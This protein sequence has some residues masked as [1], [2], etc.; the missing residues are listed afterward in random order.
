[1]YNGKTVAAVVPAYNE[2][3]LIAD[4]IKSIPEYFDKVYVVNDGSSDRTAE[5][6]SAF[7]NGR[8]KLINHPVNK[9]VGG[10]IISGYK[11]ALDDNMD[12]AVVMAGDN[13]MDPDNLSALLAPIFFDVAD[14]T[15]GDRLSKSGFQK[16]M[17]PWRRLGNFLLTWLTRIAAGNRSIQD[18]QNGYTAITNEALKKINLDDVYPWYGYCN[19]M[20]VK[21]SAYKMRIMDVPMPARYGKERSKIRYHKYIPKVSGL[22][23]RLFIWRLIG[24]RRR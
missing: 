20:L 5:I 7:T 24:S 1:M 18:P 13:Q 4:T 12:I 3:N 9:G 6:V 17:S 11:N 22:L 10:A 23:V 8:V 19:D 15:K 14:Y 16:G 2:E 21:M